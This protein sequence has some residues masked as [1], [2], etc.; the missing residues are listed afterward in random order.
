MPHLLVDRTKVNIVRLNLGWW[1]C[2]LK[3]F[4][5]GLKVPIT[6]W[7]ICYS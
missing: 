1:S 3:H 5:I 4:I 7:L 6:H 2:A